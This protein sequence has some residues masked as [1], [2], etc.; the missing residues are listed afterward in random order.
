[1]ASRKSGRLAEILKNATPKQKAILV[2]LENED[3]TYTRTKPLLSDD[4][5]EAIRRS[6]AD[7]DKEREEFNKWIHYYRV[8][9]EFVPLLLGAQMEYKYRAAETLVYFQQWE[10]IVQE[11]VH[12][13]TILETLKESGNEEIVQKYRDSLKYCYYDGAKLTFDKD[14]YVYL[15]IFQKGDL[16]DYTLFAVNRATQGLISLKSIL[17][18]F[19][20]WIKEKD[21]TDIMPKALKDMIDDCLKDYVEKLNG[22]YSLKRLREKEAHGELITDIDRKRGIFPYYQSVEE[23]PELV[24]MWERK[25]E[26]LDR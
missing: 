4:E 19:L 3:A 13:N 12:L 22:R 20:R 11:E 6:V 5:A 25:I 10:D 26:F 9:V 1:M 17:E 23:D 7:D 2:C 16:Y 14:G 18:P 15:D 21:N 24:A 8:F